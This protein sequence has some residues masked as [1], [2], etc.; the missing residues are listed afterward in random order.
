MA[1]PLSG[2]G[3]PGEE[4]PRGDPLGNGPPGNGPPQ[5]DPAGNEPSGS[6]HRGSGPAP[7]GSGSQVPA[8][9][10]PS[11]MLAARLRRA[12]GPGDRYDGVGDAEVVL[13]AGRWEEI[14]SWAM[15]RTLA[16]ARELIRRMPLA[17][18]EPGQDG[19]L[20]DA[21]AADLADQLACELS[22]AQ[23]TAAI[24]I[25]LAWELEVRLPLT[26][27]A[28]DAGVL[29]Y[30]KAKMIA[31]E[32]AALTADLARQ[33]EAQ[34][35]PHW[36]GQPHMAIQRMIALAVI[37]V[38]P[39]GARERRE[40]AE[41]AQGRVRFWRDAVNGTANLSGWDL[42][43]DQAL[44]AY[45][46]VQ[47]RARAY[48]KWG[49]DW[50]AELIRVQAYLDILNQTDYRRTH[51][52]P[53][54]APGYH[55]PDHQDRRDH[56]D[57]DNRNGPEDGNGEDD[58]GPDERNGEDDG[59]PDGN[60]EDDGGPDG[61]GEDDG[62]DG[63][64]SPD[65][66]NGGDL[67]LAANLDLTLPLATLLRLREHPGLAGNLA[68]DPALVR[69][70][71]AAAARHPGSD[72]QVILTDDTGRA[73]GFGH[74][75]RVRNR[76]GPGPPGRAPPGQH[77]LPGTSEPGQKGGTG[78]PRTS[79]AFI[80]TGDGPPGGYGTWTLDIAGTLFTV[81]LTPIQTGTPC[82]HRYESK[83]YQPS[84][85]LR[86]LVR[87]R[88]GTCVFPT[89]GWKARRTDWDHVIHWPQGRTCECNG[90]NRCRH[91]HILKQNPGWSV[92]LRPDGRHKWTTPLG[93]TYIKQPH[94]YPM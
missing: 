19:E 28:L 69:K 59:G 68:A 84:D 47:A 85:T 20:P 56:D 36:D 87:I 61:N 31:H 90:E 50:P 42:P 40:A 92:A 82:D 43:S 25:K 9:A 41:R 55:T 94:R 83:G 60:G 11:V 64:N 76:A 38:D 34:V 24:M 45:Q 18:H 32:T 57:P 93:L 1:R 52:P 10:L 71:A 91:D 72:V 66:G 89:C 35:A 23:G 17:G 67:G 22:M 70:L 13:A 73:V 12:A 62:P 15:G 8:D 3:P 88:D 29:C 5:S 81:S 78:H 39:D 77:T 21:W 79:T 14:A 58:A 80:L 74:A 44:Q 6:G 75:T 30:N 48:K 7:G 86:R 26:G 27:K 53:G 33:A 4:P 2:K 49:L 16:A 54:P 51:P 63:G 46:N 65:G 37:R